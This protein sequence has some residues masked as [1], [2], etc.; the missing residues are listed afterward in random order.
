MLSIGY[1][2]RELQIT[3]ISFLC[4]YFF[5][6]K[7]R[8]VFY[9]IIEDCHSVLRQINDILYIAIHVHVPYMDVMATFKVV[10]K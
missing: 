7:S 6:L 1:C 3:N 8:T 2:K 5:I 10:T 9:V 4:K